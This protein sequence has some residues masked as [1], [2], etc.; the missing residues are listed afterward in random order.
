M[1]QRD[2]EFTDFVTARSRALLRVAYLITGRREEAEDLVQT[3]LAK[4]YVVWPRIRAHEAVESY[5]R[6][7]MVREH[8]SLVRRQRLARTIAR[9]VT[10]APDADLPQSSVDNRLVLWAALKNLPPRQ[11]AIVVLRHYEDLSEKETAA[12][13]GCAVGTVKSQASRGLAQLRLALSEDRPSLKK[14]A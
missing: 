4:T 7:C 14:E 2:A 8:L 12:I 11:R 13:V 3:A 9:G 6:T 10:P 1:P 5:V